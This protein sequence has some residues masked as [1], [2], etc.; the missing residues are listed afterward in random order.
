MLDLASFRS[1]FSCVEDNFCKPN[2]EWQSISLE[3]A[4]ND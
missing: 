1:F 3:Q 2:L 4:Y